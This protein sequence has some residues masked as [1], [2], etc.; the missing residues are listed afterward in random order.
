GEETSERDGGQA[1]ARVSLIA[2]D[3]SQSEQRQRP[4]DAA[5]ERQD[6][7]SHWIRRCRRWLWLAHHAQDESRP[8]ADEKRQVPGSKSFV[9]DE[10]P[11]QQQIERRCVLEK[12]RIRRRRELRREDEQREGRRVHD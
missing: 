2:L 11:E 7:S 10:R 6:V 3:V 5:D 1:G 9:Y 4:R 12:D 8:D